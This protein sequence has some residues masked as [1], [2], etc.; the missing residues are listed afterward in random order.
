MAIATVTSKGQVTIPKEIRRVLR[1]EAGDRIDFIIEADDRV[2]VRRPG[3]SILDLYGILARPGRKPM[4]VR[5]MDRAIGR[6]HA[7]ENER[8]KRGRS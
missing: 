5:K 3:R 1:V 4:T 2:V 8:I 6:Y 7:R